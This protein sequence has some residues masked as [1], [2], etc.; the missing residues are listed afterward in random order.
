MFTEAQTESVLWNLV[1]YNNKAHRQFGTDII[2][3]WFYESEHYSELILKELQSEYPNITFTPAQ[4]ESEINEL[5][6]VYQA[7]EL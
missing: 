2:E 3:M 5:D 4:I 6:L 1:F 7:V